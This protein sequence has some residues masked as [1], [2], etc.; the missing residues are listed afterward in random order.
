MHHLHAL[1]DP[2]GQAGPVVCSILTGDSEKHEYEAKKQ[3]YLSY[4][5]TSPVLDIK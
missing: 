2:R 4:H 5:E 3:C 1:A